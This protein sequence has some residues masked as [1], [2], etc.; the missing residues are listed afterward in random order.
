MMAILIGIG[1]VILVM[2]IG[3]P[4]YHQRILCLQHLSS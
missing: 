4:K 1:V 3:K 2:I